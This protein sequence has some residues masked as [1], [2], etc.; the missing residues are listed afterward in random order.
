MT[1]WGPRER[2]PLHSSSATRLLVLE[3]LR[4]EEG[5]DV[6]VDDPVHELEADE[7]NREHNSRVLVD[8]GRMNAEES[9]EVS[10]EWG[11]GGQVGEVWV[12]GGREA[13]V[14]AVDVDEGGG[15]V[16]GRL[17]ALSG[18]GHGSGRAVG[19]RLVATTG[20]S[21]AQVRGLA[22]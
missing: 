7:A 19:G 10:V 21:R 22:S 11:Q 4:I 13:S 8:V 2:S 12:C 9:F 1:L 17:G 15:G 14:A 3:L 18:G 20:G 6:Q 16:R 5:R